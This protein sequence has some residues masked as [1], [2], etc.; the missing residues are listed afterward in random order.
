MCTTRTTRTTKE[1]TLASTW[2]AR[3]P[4]QS[5]SAWSRPEF[6]M[7]RPEKGTC[8]WGSM[9][10][11]FS[12]VIK[13]LCKNSKVT[14][15]RCYPKLLVLTPLLPHMQRMLG[16]LAE[17]AEPLRPCV[18]TV[19]LSLAFLKVCVLNSAWR[20][21]RSFDCDLYFPAFRMDYYILISFSTWYRLYIE[22]RQT[23]KF[24]KK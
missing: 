18:Y 6:G 13:Y 14:R 16:F 20:A 2:T 9:N 11:I 5:K 17:M 19:P 22:Y 7:S 3:F 23:D 12:N 4:S 24:F 1:W 10:Q 15:T 21:G 8:D